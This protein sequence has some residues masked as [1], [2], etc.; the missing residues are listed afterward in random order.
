MVYQRMESAKM[1]KD[2]SGKKRMDASGKV[3]CA[4]A[5]LSAR[6]R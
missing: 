4:C 1:K 3:V 5:C 2:R 6:E